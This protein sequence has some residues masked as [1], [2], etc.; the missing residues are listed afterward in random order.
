MVQWL[1]KGLVTVFL[2]FAGFDLQAQTTRVQQDA[3]YKDPN[4]HEKFRKRRLAVSAWQI[5]QLK[6]G[7]LV[8]R[9]NTGRMLIDALKRQGLDDE[10]EKARLEQAAINKNIILAYTERY[11]FSKVYF[12]PSNFSDTLLKGARSGIFV[13][14]TLNVDPSIT[15]QENFYLLAEGDYV[16]NSSI[17]FVPEDSAM[18][19]VERGNPSSVYF[20]IV[21]KNKYGHQLKAPFPYSTNKNIYLKTGPVVFVNLEGK[22]IPFVV[23]RDR[24]LWK[25]S[26]DESMSYKINGKSVQL[27]IPRMFTRQAMADLVGEFNTDLTAFY[28]SA[29]QL[30]ESNK[31]NQ[32]YKPFFY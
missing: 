20:P 22:S 19:V 15:M 11:T 14:S 9:L 1:S 5:N 24:E 8:V 6:Q 17:G 21:I 3:D 27:T 29:A 32:E 30:A 10:A 25:S 2:L 28:R 12:L 31:E 7:A 18:A 26:H 23:Q 4:T 13:D 16:Y